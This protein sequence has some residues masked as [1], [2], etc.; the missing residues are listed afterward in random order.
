MKKLIICV[1]GLLLLINI[2][3]CADRAI[4]EVTGES[5]YK[6]IMLNSEIYNKSNLNLSDIRLYDEKDE[7][8]P[9]FIN[10]YDTNKSVNEQHYP[11]KLTDSFVKDSY[12]YHDFNLAKEYTHD[13]ISTSVTIDTSN[14]NFAKT[15]EVYGGFDGANWEFVT[16]DTLYSVQ[17]SK[18][19][20]INFAQPVKY[21]YLRFKISDSAEKIKFTGGELVYN[22]T[23]TNI[24]RFTQTIEANVTSEEIDKET[25]FTV[26][27]FKNVRLRSI[28]LATKNMFKRNIRIVGGSHKV[29]YNLSFND[30]A[31]SDT[32][33]NADDFTSQKDEVKIIISNGDDKPIT[34]DKIFVTYYT[35]EIIFEYS[36]GQRVY[37][38][39]GNPEHTIPPR[40]DIDNYKDMVLS[41]KIDRLSISSIEKENAPAADV[42]KDYTWQYNL[43]I[44][45]ITIVLG[46]IFLLKLKRKSNT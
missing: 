27:G 40:Y 39:F 35:D 2:T 6:A 36:L 17:D 5:K 18:K 23:L 4:I 20:Y 37:L 9:Y 28:E 26:T 43:V 46:I 24:E 29:L 7:V 12:Y 32:V 34:V 31:Y 21:T 30:T 8:M 10:S 42:Q 11:L 13:V 45:L 14:D 15:I 3:V 38:S 19:L 33:L 22:Q 41:E 1:L 16:S 25:V 44:V